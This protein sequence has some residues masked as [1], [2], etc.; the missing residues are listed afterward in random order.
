MA[1][2][3]VGV[4]T[5]AVMVAMVA[6]TVEDGVEATV[7]EEAMVVVVV[8]EEEE[9][10]VEA[11]EEEDAEHY[12]QEHLYLFNSIM[13]LRVFCIITLTIPEI[14]DRL[15]LGHVQCNT[16][17]HDSKNNRAIFIASEIIMILQ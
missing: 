9:M 17:Y 14:I 11:V 2:V 8:E 12:G 16:V 13:P 1:V 5:V 15:D 7:G 10:A 4:G 6:E 3:M